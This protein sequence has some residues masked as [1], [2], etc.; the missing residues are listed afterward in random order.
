MANSSFLLP[1]KLRCGFFTQ[2]SSPLYLTMAPRHMLI[3]RLVGQFFMETS[4]RNEK[5]RGF[6]SQPEPMRT[7]S[8]VPLEHSW[9]GHK[10]WDYEVGLGSE[11]D[12]VFV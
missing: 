8:R 2:K 10:G 9:D 6:L 12:A 11:A 7:L 1:S 3:P 5:K 4:L